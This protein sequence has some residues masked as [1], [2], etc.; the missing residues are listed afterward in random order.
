MINL[1]KVKSTQGRALAKKTLLWRLAVSVVMRSYLTRCNL[2]QKQMALASGLISWHVSLV[3]T[4]NGLATATELKQLCAAASIR[5][6]DFL[7]SVKHVQ[8]DERLR[9]AVCQ[10]LALLE[11]EFF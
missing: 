3:I 1:T 6:E 9:A 4:A 5:F 10:H 8:S 2:S 11:L 7:K